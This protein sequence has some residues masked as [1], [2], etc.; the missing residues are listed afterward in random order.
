[1]ITDS[2]LQSSK[3]NQRNLNGQWKQSKLL[4]ILKTLDKPTSAESTDT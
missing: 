1:M 4:K 3:E 2:H